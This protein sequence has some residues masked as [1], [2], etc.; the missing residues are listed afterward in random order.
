MPLFAT[1]LRVQNNLSS[2]LGCDPRDDFVIWR[3]YTAWDCRDAACDSCR[4][5]QSWRASRPYSR[6]HEDRR[7]VNHSKSNSPVTLQPYV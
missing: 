6:V 1:K 5:V 7:V 3:E 4:M 2:S